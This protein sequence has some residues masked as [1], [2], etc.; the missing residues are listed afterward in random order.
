MLIN[1]VHF[2]EK[3]ME[4]YFLFILFYLLLF[5]YSIY[6]AEQ[7]KHNMNK[8]QTQTHTCGAVRRL[9]LVLELCVLRSSYIY[10][11]ID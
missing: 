8:K 7:S 10:S 9:Y 2:P 3:I 4:N 6:Y 5:I 1:Y 11:K